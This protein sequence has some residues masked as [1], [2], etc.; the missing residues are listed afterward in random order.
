MAKIRIMALRHS[1]FYSPLLLTINGG[2]L[3]QQG[4]EPEYRVSTPADFYEQNLL[5]GR[6]ELA[7]AAPAVGFAA[8]EKG[9]TPAI[10]HFAAIN[11]R[12]GF[13]LTAR[14]TIQA[15]EWS[16]LEGSHVLV[17]HL[18]QPYAT[19][20]YAMHINAADFDRIHVTDAGNVEQMD[21]AFRDG[22]G[23]FIHHQGPAPQQLQRDGLGYCVASVGEA[24]G[25][26]AFSS[27]CATPDWLATDM[28]G[29]FMAAYRQA[30]EDIVDMPA[31][32]LAKAIEVFLPGTDFDVLCQTLRYYQKLGTWTGDTRIRAE[33]YEKLLDVF[34]HTGLISRRYPMDSL[35]VNLD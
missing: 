19:L 15:F 2:Y 25:P 5:E 30:V 21:R 13:F 17:D 29:A 34:M 27:L 32:R 33:S 11:D 12:D 23:D 35:I 24:I 16:M 18:F 6:I 9:E 4:L 20:Q 7:Q 8:L 10:R 26:L 28:C 1:A 31:E 3:Q 22:Q 14:K